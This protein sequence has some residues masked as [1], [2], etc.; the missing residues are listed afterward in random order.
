MLNTISLWPKIT[1][2]TLLPHFTH[3]SNGMSYILSKYIIHMRTETESHLELYLNLNSYYNKIIHMCTSL[4]YLNL[5]SHIVTLFQWANLQSIQSFH[6]NPC[7]LWIAFVAKYFLIQY[8]NTMLH[9]STY[10][11][12]AFM[13]PKVTK[14]HL[15]WPKEGGTADILGFGDIVFGTYFLWA[16]T[17]FWT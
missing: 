2:L 9:C 4:W 16:K 11:L 12:R 5:F 3:F 15:I 7:A 8:Y 13:S 6:I 1:I 14:E 10:V 17:P